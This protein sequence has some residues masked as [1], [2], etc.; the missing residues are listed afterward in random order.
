MLRVV[1]YRQI[2]ATSLFSHPPQ[3]SPTQPQT[4]P[5]TYSTDCSST[6][7]KALKHMLAKHRPRRR[8]ARVSF[9]KD[10]CYEFTNYLLGFSE[11]DSNSRSAFTFSIFNI[12]HVYTFCLLDTAFCLRER[13]RAYV[14]IHC[15]I[16]KFNDDVYGKFVFSA[17][18]KEDCSHIMESTRGSVFR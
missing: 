13:W 3:T 12:I 8:C 1:L 15:K 10:A 14:D 11:K 16:N 5:S 2:S 4:S 18:F 7:G 17:P 9:L 6:L